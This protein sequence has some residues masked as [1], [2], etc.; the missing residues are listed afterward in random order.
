MTVDDGD[1]ALQLVR[2]LPV[3]LGMFLLSTAFVAS[4]AAASTGE[5]V[6][7]AANELAP[8]EQATAELGRAKR[9]GAD[10]LAMLA[11]NAAGTLRPCLRAGRGWERIRAVEH[12]PQRAL[13]VA[14][15]RRLLADM[16]VLLEVQRPRIE[17]Y[18]PAFE[19]YVG[20]LN[21]VVVS[22]PLVAQAIA[23]QGRRLVAYRDVRSVTASCAVFNRLTARVRELPTRSAAEIVRVDYRST[24]VARRIERH[25]SNQLAAIDRR[26]GISYRDALTLQGAAE[27]MVAAG[28]SPGA[29][30]GFQYALSLR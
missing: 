9:T 19:R 28:G 29:A 6:A 26:H 24:R 17:T 5:V 1:V 13:Y 22:S 10:K 25:V 21:A 16:R 30:L 7:R 20:A 2:R 12:S 14:A 8:I 23:A 27:Q 15:A 3:I 4:T 18:W 11:R